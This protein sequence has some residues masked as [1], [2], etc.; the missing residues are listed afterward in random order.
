MVY[1][2]HEQGCDWLCREDG[3]EDMFVVALAP[4]SRF[5]GSA[6]VCT[7]I[8][9]S[10]R[11]VLDRGELRSSILPAEFNYRVVSEF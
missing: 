8:G 4:P 9:Q 11:E 2:D 5:L 1:H 6:L 10:R 3:I 7:C